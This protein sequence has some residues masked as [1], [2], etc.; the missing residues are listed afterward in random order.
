MTKPIMTGGRFTV[1]WDIVGDL[2][3]HANVLKMPHWNNPEPCWFCR[4]NL[5]NYNWMDM[6][7]TAKWRATIRTGPD[8][9]AAPARPHPLFRIMRPAGVTDAMVRP[10]IMHSMDL[11]FLLYLH[12]GVLKTL[13]TAETS[14]VPGRTQQARLDR[15]WTSIR[16]FYKDFGVERRILAL[17]L[18]KFMPE[19]STDFASLKAKAAQSKALLP[20]MLA[21]C[22]VYNTGS[23]FDQHRVATY[24]ALV[25]FYDILKRVRWV[26]TDEQAIA[27]EESMSR[28]LLHY[29]CLVVAEKRAGRNTF[30]ETVKF[31]FCMHIA[32][33]AVFDNPCMTSEYGYEDM[34]GRIVRI[35]KACTA[36]MPHRRVARK[37][38][39]KVR[40][41][42]SLLARRIESRLT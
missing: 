17:T 26:P 15:V 22:R 12:G 40:A 42:M 6:R 28:A 39:G 36:S 4:A 37:A 11:G 41:L 3:H 20:V 1:L 38:L 32:M 23:E 29:H 24:A 30:N 5:T 9:V 14:S 21:V 34:M 33:N 25:E 2:E 7:P 18:S 13:V 35:C 31:H 16:G 19:K 8:F 10:G 27:I